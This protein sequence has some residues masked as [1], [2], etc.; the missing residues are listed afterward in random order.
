MRVLKVFNYRVR[1]RVLRDGFFFRS[2]GDRVLF[3]ILSDSVLFKFLSDRVLSRVLSDAVFFDFSV[4]DSSS[5]VID[6]FFV[7]SVLFFRYATIFLSKC[8][9]TFSLL[10]KDVLFYITFSK[11][12]SHLTISLTFSN[13]FQHGRRDFTK[14]NSE[15]HE[16]Y[17]NDRNTA[18][19]TEKNMSSISRFIICTAEY[20]AVINCVKN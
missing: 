18:Y 9:T 11:R 19:H 16:K 17:L 2:V 15:K 20:I 12:R 5:S 7:P 6:S 14:T 1:S 4:I 3:R 10:K 8:A 13:R